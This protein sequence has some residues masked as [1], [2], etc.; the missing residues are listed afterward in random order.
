MSSPD[1]T[2]SARMAVDTEGKKNPV[3]TVYYGLSWIFMDSD[4]VE[5]AGVE[6]ASANS[7]Q[8]ILHA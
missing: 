3:K 1:S 2:G 5:A 4:L 8:S 7:P 6:P